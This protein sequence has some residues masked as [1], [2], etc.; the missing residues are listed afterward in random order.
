LRV[1]LVNDRPFE[2]RLMQEAFGRVNPAIRWNVVSDGDEL[3][4]FLRQ[5]GP[6]AAA[7][8]PQLIF[9]DLDLSRSDAGD[10][11]TRIKS[12]ADFKSIPVVVLSGS[13]RE[14]DIS[15][16]YRLGANSCVA[17]S[18]RSDGFEQMIWGINN[19]WLNAATLPVE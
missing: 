11:L 13:I 1:L 4:G 3:M 19:F 17:K 5:E 15:R 6:H 18:S 12:D 9:L 10:A 7:P 2:V 8:R 16:S 14:A